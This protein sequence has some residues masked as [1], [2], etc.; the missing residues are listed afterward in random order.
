[1]THALGDGMQ[2]QR[3][4]GDGFSV[5]I[6]LGQT[7]ENVP[8][9]IKQRDHARRQATACEILRDEAAPAP[10]ILQFVE[11]ILSVSAVAIELAEAPHLLDERSH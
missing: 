1:M 7:N 9:I 6:R 5:P 11:N 8:P 4:A 3:S 10:L 2:Q